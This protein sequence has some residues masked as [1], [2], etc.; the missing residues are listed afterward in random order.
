MLR[1]GYDPADWRALREE[2]DREYRRKPRFGTEL[3][4]YHNMP[5]S[6]ACSDFNVTTRTLDDV[7][8]EKVYSTKEGR[9]RLATRRATHPMHPQW[10]GTP[11]ETRI[12]KTTTQRDNYPADVMDLRR[13]LR[14]LCIFHQHGPM[15]CT[16]CGTIVEA[17]KDT[18]HWASTCDYSTKVWRTMSGI[19]GLDPETLDTVTMIWGPLPRQSTAWE[20]RLVVGFTLLHLKHARFMAPGTDTP[21]TEETIQRILDDWGSRG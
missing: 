19:M 10:V 2:I 8:T 1:R 21:Q 7:T 11:H 5:K 16:M 3:E 4:P 9:R 20:N 15:R 13:R 12:L 17:G 18:V 14:H 6:S